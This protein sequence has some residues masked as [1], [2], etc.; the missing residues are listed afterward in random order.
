MRLKESLS[1]LAVTLLGIGLAWLGIT[2]GWWPVSLAVLVPAGLGMGSSWLGERRLATAP[3]R[4]VR[5]MEWWVLVPGAAA[6]LAQ[7]L[8]IILG[9]RLELD[10]GASVQVRQLWAATIGAVSTFLLVTFVRGAEEADETW[11][12]KRVQRAFFRAAERSWR[13]PKGSTGEMAIYSQG[14][15]GLHGWGRQARRRRAREVANALSQAEPEEG[16]GVEG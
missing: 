3:E 10:D 16:A 1:A 9:M 4:A 2:V 7:C 15:Q 5:W 6:A 11:V 13:F 8:V 14:W 12:G